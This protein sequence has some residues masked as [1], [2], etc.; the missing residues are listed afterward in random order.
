MTRAHFKTGTGTLEVAKFAGIV[1][2]R[3]EPVPVLKPPLRIFTFCEQ[4]RI[5]YHRRSPPYANLILKQLSMTEIQ[6]IGNSS[7]WSDVVIWSGIAQWVE[8]A[9]DRSQDC[10]SQI[11]QVLAQIDAT[12]KQIGSSRTDLLQVLIYLADLNE[13][14][15]LNELWDQWVP[16][17][18]APVRA[19]VGAVLGDQCCVEMVIS[20]ACRT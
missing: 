8:V 19:C 20:A 16:G 13:I 4:L 7:R 11:H 1:F 5:L 15:I 9:E 17:G 2:A 14:S 3:R 12:L 6:R 18:Q 10:R